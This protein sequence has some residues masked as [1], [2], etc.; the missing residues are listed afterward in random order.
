MSPQS[1]RKSEITHF[2]VPIHFQ[3]KHFAVEKFPPAS[4][5][6]QPVKITFTYQALPAMMMIAFIT[7][8]RTSLHLELFHS[9]RLSV[10]VQYVLILSMRLHS[11]YSDCHSHYQRQLGHGNVKRDPYPWNKSKEIYTICQKRL[12]DTF[13]KYV[14]SDRL[15]CFRDVFSLQYHL[16][17]HTLN[18]SGDSYWRLLQGPHALWTVH[19]VM[20][21]SLY[22]HVSACVYVY[23]CACVPGR[24]RV[25]VC[26]A[27]VCW[28]YIQ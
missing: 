28:Q 21:I 23:V 10:R 3:T 2:C 22:I 18:G 16:R 25:R 12:V 5:L 1:G 7:W 17:A 14:Q 26:G 11:S 8:R 6:L 13:V 15:T 19:T 20:D 24:V 27:H 9:S 4:L